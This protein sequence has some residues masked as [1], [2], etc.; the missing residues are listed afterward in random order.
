MFGGEA[1]RLIEAFRA[2]FSVLFGGDRSGGGSAVCDGDTAAGSPG[3]G[4]GEEDSS[5]RRRPVDAMLLLSMLQRRGRFVDFLM[6]DVGGVP[7]EQLGAAVRMLHRECAEVL[8]EYFELV[9]V[10]EGAEG[11]AVELPSVRPGEVECV[12]EARPGSRV[13]L[14]HH[15]WRIASVRK[16]P[17]VVDEGVVD[18]VAPA[19][20]EPVE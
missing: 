10:L 9:P 7:D 5:G 19:R 18:V 12:C 20:V 14:V 6:E 4:A 11:E 13:R 17:V 3:A 15:G 8:G 16:W 1:V 2:F